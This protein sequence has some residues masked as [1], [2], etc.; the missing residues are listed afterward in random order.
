MIK[1]IDSTYAKADLGKLVNASQLNVEEIT[2]LLSLC[3]DFEDLFDGNFGNR[4]T[5]DVELELNPDPTPFNSRYY[6]VARTN[7]ETF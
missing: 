2:L 1:I 7:K 6:P 4:A 5:E 3:E